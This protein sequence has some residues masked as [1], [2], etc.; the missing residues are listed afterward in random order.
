MSRFLALPCCVHGWHVGLLR[1][2]G[3]AG[4]NDGGESGEEEGGL[5]SRLVQFDDVEPGLF[6]LGEKAKAYLKPTV[7]LDWD[8]GI[9]HL[10]C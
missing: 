7:E 2:R 4:G 3:H 8:A 10:H 1:G 6:S 5:A 9:G